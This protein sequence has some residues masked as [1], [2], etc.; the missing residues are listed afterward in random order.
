MNDA[1]VRVSFKDGYA[2]M[3]I[4]DQVA[5]RLTPAKARELALALLEAASKAEGGKEM[6]W[7]N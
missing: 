5:V 7:Q 3:D 4:A 2:F 1:M 6:K